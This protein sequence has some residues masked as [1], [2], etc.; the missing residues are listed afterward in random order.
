MALE[1]AEAAPVA[2]ALETAAAELHRFARNHKAQAAQHRRLAQ[3]AMEG[4][5]RLRRD[6]EAAGI[7]L[8]IAQEAETHV[9]RS[10]G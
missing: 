4:L 10:D 6:C 8:V 7:H 2:R 1:R 5:A 9:P 3:Q